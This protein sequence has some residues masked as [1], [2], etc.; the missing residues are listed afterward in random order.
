[1]PPPS[2]KPS[3][4]IKNSKTSI[5]SSLPWPTYSCWQG[6][7]HQHKLNQV[8]KT[9]LNFKNFMF[10]LYTHTPHP[11]IKQWFTMKVMKEWWWRGSK[12]L[13]LPC[14]ILLMTQYILLNLRH[15]IDWMK[16]Y[17]RLFMALVRDLLPESLS[18]FKSVSEMFL[19]E[20]FMAI[21]RFF[22]YC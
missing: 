8:S 9:A 14:H 1:M 15:L 13:N 11:P 21:F 6:W 4:F 7:K 5:N 2:P 16:W 3:I 10:R 22:L 20:L 19:F 18:Q 17:R 12:L